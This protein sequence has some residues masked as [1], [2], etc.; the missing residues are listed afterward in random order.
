MKKS[1]LALSLLLT[2]ASQGQ[3]QN[4]A[5]KEKIKHLFAVMHQDSLIIKTLDA[6]TS[7]MVKNM[8]VL[9]NDTAYTNHGVDVSTL[10]QKMME[11]SMQRSKENALKLLNEDM[12]DI[13]DKYFTIEEIEEFTAFYSTKSG[14]KWL[15]QTPDITK[16]VMTVMSTKYQ[17]DFQQS[18]MKDMEE[19]TKEITEQMKTKQ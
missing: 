16:D 7:A 3:A 17:Q 4:S 14:Q 1:L 12:V 19:I 11:R 13:Y 2:L 15:T 18:Y 10:T 8:S 6:T 9:F 5:K